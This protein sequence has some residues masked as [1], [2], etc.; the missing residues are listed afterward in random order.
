[1]FWR[2]GEL[3]GG[4]VGGC[5]SIGLGARHSGFLDYIS[6]EKRFLQDNLKT[7]FGYR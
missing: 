3:L 2:C 5:I 4:Q 1:M 6:E 7:L